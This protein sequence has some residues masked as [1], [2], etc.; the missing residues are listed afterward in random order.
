[1]ITLS[2]PVA[3][4]TAF[5]EPGELVLLAYRDLEVAATG[6]QEQVRLLGALGA[7]P[8]PW[9]PASCANARLQEELGRGWI[10]LPSG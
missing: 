4:V 5:P 7:L 9:N 2:A 10:G 1:M 8:R 6:E 3:S